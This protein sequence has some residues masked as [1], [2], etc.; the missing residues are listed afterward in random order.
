[1]V[2]TG[3]MINVRGALRSALADALARAHA[4]GELPEVPPERVLIQY[5]PP[6]Q[7]DLG[8]YASPIA[9]SLGKELK[10]QPMEVA[11][12]IAKHFTPPEFVGKVEGVA[13]G[14][15][16][17]RLNPGWLVQKLDDIVEEG[18]QFGQSQLGQ[19]NTVN[20]EFVSANPTGLPT[21]GNGRALFWADTLGRV[22]ENSGYA[23]TREYYVNDMGTQ[24]QL[25]GESVLRRILQTHGSAIPFPENLYQGEEVKEIARMVEERLTEDTQ[26]VFS[27]DDLS[28]P[29]FIQYVARIAVEETIRAIREVIE[30]VCGVRYDI[31]SFEHTFHER[32]D[33][34]TTLEDLKKTGETYEKEGALWF[35]S[36]KFGDDKDRVLVRKNGEVTYLV[37]DIAYHRDKF[38]RGFS[39]VADFWGADHYG[40]IAR[41]RG[42]L[43]ALGEDVSR[44][45]VVIAQIVHVL[46]EG[47][48]QKMS[49]R[50]GTSVPLHEIVEL[51]GVSASRFFLTMKALSS[52]FEFDVRLAQE[53]T[54]RNPVYYV[55]Y[56]HVR[57]S[58]LLRKAK[59]QN[60][61]DG[62]IIPP[63]GA[64]VPLTHTAELALMRHILRFPE[65]VEDVALSWEVQRL[66]HYALELA[67][68]IHLFYDAVPVL[69][70]DTQE[71]QAARL[72]L[73][74]A[75]KTTLGNALD[76]L[77][78]EKRDIM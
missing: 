7:G 18:S 5:P 9:L 14:F 1:M 55:Q 53:E 59:E 28:N 39:T 32:S 19:G 63:L 57:L 44:F 69:T 30:R 46:V 23:V 2:Y 17:I 73:A 21:F 56:A 4:A 33:V 20:L 11:E 29:E 64:R 40:Y 38:R 42:A 71:L 65:V 22:L 68:A 78:V 70:A 72:T 12:T 49:K 27:E 13:P 77:G 58:S 25:Y 35:R 52:Q 66:P 51:A 36:T 60:I 31:W 6:G 54:E 74:L 24:V 50:A 43:Q 48:Q 67:K 15:L 10:K 16:N 45:R 3:R 41:L 37:A 62:E 26:H 61:V 34:A 47:E 76:L 8:D 75:A